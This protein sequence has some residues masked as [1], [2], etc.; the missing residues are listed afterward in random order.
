MKCRNMVTRCAQAEMSIV[1][2]FLR[3]YS[4][5]EWMEYCFHQLNERT[6]TSY[7]GQYRHREIGK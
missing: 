4:L 1:W 5:L 3:L 6:I 2:K 7:I